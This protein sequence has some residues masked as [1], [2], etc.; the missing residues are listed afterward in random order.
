MSTDLEM[1]L[2]EQLDLGREILAELRGAA[3][4]ENRRNARNSFNASIQ[5]Y[6]DGVCF[7]GVWARP[8]LDHKQR[9]LIVIAQLIALNRPVQL[10]SHLS[11]AL[12]L[13]YSVTELQEVLLQSAVYCGLPTALEAFRVAEEVLTERELLP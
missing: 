3:F 8:G 1:S 12:D 13:G 9:A 6:T 7:G 4:L 5:D 10:K 2:Q 11:G